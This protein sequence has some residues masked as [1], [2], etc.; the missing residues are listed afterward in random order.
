[1][2]KTVCVLNGPNLNLLGTREPELYGRATLAEVEKLCRDTAQRFG[3]A[4]DFRQSNHEGEI[5]DWIQNAR[6]DKAVGLIINPAG[7]TTTSVAILDALHM[8]EA[9]VIEVHITNI[10]ARE[11]FRRHSYVSRVAR[12]VICGFGVEGYALA[13]TGLAALIGAQ[14]RSKA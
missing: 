2:P 14:Q 6:A 13:I 10:H 4:V 11:A 8:I 9:P 1:M 5:V 3:L 12:A 7:Y